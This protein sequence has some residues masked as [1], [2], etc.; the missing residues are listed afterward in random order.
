MLLFSY[1]TLATMQAILATAKINMKPGG[2]TC[3][4]WKNMD[5]NSTH[6]AQHHEINHGPCS[7]EA[8]MLPAAP[9]CR[10]AILLI[11]CELQ[12]SWKYS[13]LTLDARRDKLWIWHQSNP[14][15]IVYV[16]I[17]RTYI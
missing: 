11:H 16:R 14:L 5:R 7:C 10:P 2:R 15:L 4:L 13:Q 9:P 17:T 6:T 8:L 3:R 1:E 12:D